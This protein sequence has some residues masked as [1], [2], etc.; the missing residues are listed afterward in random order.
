MQYG[1]PMRTIL[2][3][4]VALI[5]SGSGAHRTPLCNLGSLH[6]TAS[7]QGATGSQLG[8]VTVSNPGRSCSF[9]A[10]P[11]IEIDW[12]GRRLTPP[13]RPFPSTFSPGTRSR[14]LPDGDA[15]FVALQWWNYCGPPLPAGAQTVVVVRVPGEPGVL[16]APLAGGSLA[17]PYCNSSQG[18]AL[19]VGDF[20]VTSPVAPTLEPQSIGPVSFGTAKPAAV[21]QLTALL[22]APTSRGI[23]TGCGPRY[24]EVRWHD[25]A[26]EF[27]LGKLSGYRYLTKTGAVSPKLE[28]A[29]GISLGSTLG[30]TRNAYGSLARIGADSW[31]ARDGLVF[32]DD[33]KRDPVPPTSRIVEIKI[34][35]CGAF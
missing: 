30:A 33:A 8:G 12:R 35:T 31:R 23:N 28:T 18:A 11:V 29:A 7:F 15:R 34:G 24:T 32:V 9:A 26:V 27:R 25:L 3:G 14:L 6:G 5:A 2:V 21:R 17:P 19:D 13:G 1:R 16:R 22:G 10:R 20:T 4:V